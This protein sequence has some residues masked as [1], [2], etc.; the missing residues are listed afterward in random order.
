MPLG[1]SAALPVFIA[2]LALCGCASASN[3]RASAQQQ[4]ATGELGLGSIQWTGRFAP[5]LQAT[6]SIS[7][8]SRNDVHGDVRLTAVDANMLRAQITFSINESTPLSDNYRWAIA[9]GGCRSNAI[10]LMPVSEFPPLAV[11]S[12][13]GSLD[14]RVNLPLPNSGRY[15][16]NIYW[17][18]GADESDVMT[19]AELTL[20]KKSP[21]P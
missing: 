2:A 5:T 14:T 6:K 17:T 11:T 13:R 3:Q 1:R 21:N 10:P 19:C 16:L 20:T 9:S 15:H 7:G 18:N 4:A 12:N 8:S